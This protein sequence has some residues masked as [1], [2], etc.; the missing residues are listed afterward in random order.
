MRLDKQVPLSSEQFIP[1]N[2]ALPGAVNWIKGKVV[3]DNIGDPDLWR[4]HNKLY[5]LSGYMVNHPGGP[6]WLQ[7]LCDFVS[8]KSTKV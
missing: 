5:D 2:R 6:E 1:S 8:E 7:G 4:I 3:D